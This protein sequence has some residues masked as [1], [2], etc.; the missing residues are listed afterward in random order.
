MDAITLVPDTWRCP[1]ATSHSNVKIETSQRCN[2][3][4]GSSALHA[5]GQQPLP[6]ESLK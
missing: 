3:R 2:D 5:R 6:N 1:D 4:Y